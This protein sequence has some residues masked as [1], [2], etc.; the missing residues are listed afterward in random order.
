MDALFWLDG[1]CNL[2]LSIGYNFG[3]EPGVEGFKTSTLKT[4]TSYLKLA[5]NTLLRSRTFATTFLILHKSTF[6]RRM[7]FG[8]KPSSQI[9]LWKCS[10]YVSVFGEWSARAVAGPWDWLQE[11]V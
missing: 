2:V 6:K 9:G 7:S 4:A 5:N 11:G 3:F 10:F 8:L 1:Y